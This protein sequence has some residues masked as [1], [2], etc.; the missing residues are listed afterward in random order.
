VSL[1]RVYRMTLTMSGPDRLDEQ[2][3]RDFNFLDR[4]YLDAQ[5]QLNSQLQSHGVAMVSQL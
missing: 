4:F 1:L 5:M 2:L 3:K